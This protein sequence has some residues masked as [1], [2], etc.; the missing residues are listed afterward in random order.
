M[1]KGTDAEQEVTD[2]EQTNFGQ[3]EGEGPDTFHT[4]ALSHDRIA[5]RAYE[6]FQ[7]GGKLGKIVLT[8]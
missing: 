2:Q 8:P 5:A 6:R 1:R 4:D 7:A 3:P